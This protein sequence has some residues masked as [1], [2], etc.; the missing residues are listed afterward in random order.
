MIGTRRVVAALLATGAVVTLSACGVTER[1]AA[2]VDGQDISVADFDALAQ[3]YQA[4][5]AATTS[6]DPSA[7]EPADGGGA[8]S[9]P[10]ARGLLGQVIVGR[11]IES[12]LDSRDALPT[13]E[14]LEGAPI[15][16]YMADLPDGVRRPLQIYAIG[17]SAITAAV[18]DDEA[19][20]AY[21]ATAQESTVLCP[22]IIVTE[23]ED[24]A[25]DIIAQL[26]EGAD[27][28]ELASAQTYDANLAASGGISP[29]QTGA[30]CL[31]TSQLS[32]SAP[33]GAA[34]VSLTPGTWTAPVTAQIDAEG[35]MGWFILYQRPYEEVSAE[36]TSAAVGQVITEFVGDVDVAVDPMYGRW[37][38]DQFSVV[39]L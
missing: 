17:T 14:E 36:V 10:T 11:L 19:A 22:R 8:I 21:D 28:A 27:F 26:E 38:A 5:Q 23:T 3:A 33:V 39:A 6:S 37:D 2:T 34:A 29:D 32:P 7:P 15:E 24:E 4:D 20:A 13:A 9:G 16:A 1:T 18:T 35:N 12:F 30:E 25:N 31:A